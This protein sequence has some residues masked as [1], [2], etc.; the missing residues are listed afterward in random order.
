MVHTD[1]VCLDRFVLNKPEDNLIKDFEIPQEFK[2]LMPYF[3][4]PFKR[5]PELNLKKLINCWRHNTSYVLNG[6]VVYS[7]NGHHFYGDST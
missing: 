6:R 5:L 2:L 1:S 4:N 3:D 7:W